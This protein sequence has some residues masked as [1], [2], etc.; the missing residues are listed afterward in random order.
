MAPTFIVMAPTFIVMAPTFI[1]M[2]PTFVVM[3]QL[4]GPPIQAGAN[5]GSSPNDP[6]MTK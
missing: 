4:S 3:A 5:T 2:A 1:V 6:A